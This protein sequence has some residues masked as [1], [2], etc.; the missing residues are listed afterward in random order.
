[1]NAARAWRNATNRQREAVLD[2][3]D[4][5]LFKIPELVTK[6]WLELDPRV[7]VKIESIWENPERRTS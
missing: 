6:D 3:I 7:R 4:V 1:M 2:A 5:P